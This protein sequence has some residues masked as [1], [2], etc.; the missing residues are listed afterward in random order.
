M[1]Q[2]GNP[3]GH[4]PAEVTELLG[5]EGGRWEVKTLRSHHLF[6]LDRQT[7]TRI[8]GPTALP[9]VN[10]VSRPIRTIEVCAVGRRG[11]WIMEPDDDEDDLDYYWQLTGLVVQIA[12]LSDKADL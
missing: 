9:S 12:R 8:P 10:D 2:E 4:E 11:Y 3:R 6:D 5:S 7:V 1:T